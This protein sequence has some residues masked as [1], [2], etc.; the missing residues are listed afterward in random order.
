[1]I[2]N[3]TNLNILTQGV[4]AAWNDAYANAPSD[5]LEDLATVVSSETT[6]EIY[7]LVAELPQFRE[8]VGDRI[9]RDIATYDYT[10]RNRDWELTLSLDRNKVLDDKYGIWMQHSVPQIARNGKRK[11]ALLVRDAL[12][13]GHLTKCFDG[14]NFFDPSHPI[15]KFPGGGFS[16]QTQS[17][18]F[19][20]TPLNPTNYQAVRAAMMAFKGESGEALNVYP[21]LLIVPPQLE[22]MARSILNGDLIATAS[23]AGQTM[24]GGYSNPLKGS[25]KLL[26]LQ[27]LAVDADTWYLIDSS[28][29]VKPIIYQN[30]QEPILVAQFSPQDESCYKRKKFEW[31][32]DM[33]G[34]AGYALWFLACK[35]KGS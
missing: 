12:R 22:G 24:V 15:N 5:Y 23:F 21:D 7:P 27:D 4:Q 11:P 35:V 34:T 14:Q 1:M 31:G 6:E 33:R 19:T 18:Y 8:W 20:A 29:P 16:G 10:L 2:I 25:A 3:S 13:N 26:V 9:A 28:K 17:N 32:A 30:R